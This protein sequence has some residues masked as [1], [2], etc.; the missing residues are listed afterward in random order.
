MIQDLAALLD[1]HERLDVLEEAF[2]YDD[3]ADDGCES[4]DLAVLRSQI[5]GQLDRLRAALLSE[6][7]SIDVETPST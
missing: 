2:Y 5:G 3:E 4:A 7:V 1:A 6:G